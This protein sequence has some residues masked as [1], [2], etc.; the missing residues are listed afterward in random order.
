M[1]LSPDQLAEYRR[2][3]LLV[4]HSLF[5]PAEVE[6]LSDAFDADCLV[7]GPQRILEEGGQ[8][9][10]AV[11]AS[12]DRRREFATLVRTPRLLGPARQMMSDRL[13]IYQ[14]KINAKPAFGGDKWAWHQDYLA[15]RLADN[16]PAPRQVNVGLFLDEVTEFN[17]PL[18]FIPGSHRAGQLRDFRN[19]SARS[20]QHLD[21]DDIALRPEQMSELVD[22]HGMVSPKGPAG[23]V[24]FFDP[25]IVHGS[26]P[27]MSPFARRLLIITYNESVNEPRPL[28]EPRPSYVVGRD[29]TPL[30]FSDEPIDMRVGGAV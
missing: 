30:E 9:V 7:P 29:T 6:A 13:Y 12:H 27:N 16:L 24:I 19:A 18:I 21:P 15:W 1:Q 22:R 11:Y 20:E 25:E 8:A 14:F 10:R 4:V 17:G 5:K 28:G 3:G 23:S 26:A 2:T